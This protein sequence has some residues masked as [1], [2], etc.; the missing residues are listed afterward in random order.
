MFLDTF[1]VYYN[2]IFFFK[3]LIFVKLVFFLYNFNNLYVF[4]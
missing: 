4:N 3:L 1:Y 2:G